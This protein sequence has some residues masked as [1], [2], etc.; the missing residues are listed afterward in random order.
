MNASDRVEHERAMRAA[1][2][3][4][5]EAAWRAWYDATYDALYRYVQWRCGGRRDWADEI[6]QETWMAAVRRVRRF[7]P[8]RASFAAWLRGIAI[9]VLRNHLRRR[10]TFV[11]HVRPLGDAPAVEETN[12]RATELEERSRR[13]MRTL[14]ALPEPYETVLR[15][16]YVDRQT[17][18]Q[19]AAAGEETVKAVESRLGRARRAF[20]EVYEKF[21]TNGK[22]TEVSDDPS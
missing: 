5:D 12:G 16:K 10:R 21:E 6:V 9:N 1:V 14:D 7:D 2:L 15:A 3:A 8:A 18:A 20:R 17:V 11:R 13:I 4:G 19:I 22:P